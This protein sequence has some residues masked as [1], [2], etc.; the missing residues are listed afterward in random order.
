MKRVITKSLLIILLMLPAFSCKKFL[1]T[2]SQ[3]NDFLTTAQDLD[4]LLI[5]GGYTASFYGNG[6]TQ[7]LFIM[8]D[9]VEENPKPELQPED[10][11]QTSY[12]SGYYNWQ[13]NPY[14]YSDGTQEDNQV[15]IFTKVY[16]SISTVNTVIFNV[17]LMREKGEPDDILTRVDGE[18]HFLRA[19]YYFLLVNTYG[20][21]YNKATA[22]TDYG[23]PLKTDPAIEAGFF[24]RATVQEVYDQMTND[25]LQAEKELEGYNKGSVIRANQAAAQA[26]LS[27]IYLYTEAYEKAV[28]YADKVLANNYQISNLNN[29]NF[30]NNFLQLSSPETIF[31]MGEDAINYLYPVF[32][33]CLF[34]H[35]LSA[36]VDTYRASDDLLQSFET[37]DLRPSV[38]FDQGDRPGQLYAKVRGFDLSG[39]V[40]EIFLIRAPE[41][42]LNKAEALAVLGRNSEAIGTLQEL[43]KKRF[44]VTPPSPPAAGAALVN[45]VR[46]ER[47]RELCFEGHRW[48]DLRRYGVNDQYPFSKSIRHN[49]YAYNSSLASY[50]Q[51]YYELKPYS[52]DAAAYVVPLHPFDIQF[53]RGTL[54][55]EPRPARPL[56]Q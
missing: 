53:N 22:K 14:I 27:R 28:S 18:A 55:N 49:S 52:Q 26:L 50:L 5:G 51:G 46:D 1:K 12:F 47:R 29:F 21:P 8:D 13:P 15:T 33:P 24:S 31:N 48:F 43:R 34:T 19:L 41:V 11:V 40:S 17:P 32:G 20:K 3:N 38:F 10:I 7:M 25:L 30:A 6:R 56:I 2:Q 16:K 37:D 44:A 35:D 23:V 4:E 42:Y 54:T 36:T 39:N 9:D 45:F